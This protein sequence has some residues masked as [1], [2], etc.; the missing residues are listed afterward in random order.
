VSRPLG[1]ARW[2][3]VG[4]R[5]RGTAGWRRERGKEGGGGRCA[6]AFVSRPERLGGRS[7]LGSS[8]SSVL[9][10]STTCWGVIGEAWKKGSV[11]RRTD[12]LLLSHPKCIREERE[13]V[14]PVFVVPSFLP[15]LS[16]PRHHSLSICPHHPDWLLGALRQ[17]WTEDTLG[18]AHGLARLSRDGLVQPSSQ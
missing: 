3:L 16:C 4:S 7:C 9:E 13:R 15:L 8:L 1:H 6:C 14:G 11:G 5:G 17:R 12:S 10:G 18:D 2:G